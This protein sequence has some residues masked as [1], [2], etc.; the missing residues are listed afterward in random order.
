MCAGRLSPEGIALVLD[1]LE[2][3]GIYCIIED[4]SPVSLIVGAMSL[5]RAVIC[6][7]KV[8]SLDSAII[9]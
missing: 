7:V 3:R 8:G 1:T 5:H 4:E 6:P 2:S 9:I